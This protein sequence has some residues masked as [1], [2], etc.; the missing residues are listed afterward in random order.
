MPSR[1]IR[2]NL[3]TTEQRR[4]AAEID[5]E[6]RM[7][8]VVNHSSSATTGQ[9]RGQYRGDAVYDPL[10]RIY[11]STTVVGRSLARSASDKS[12]RSSGRQPGRPR[13][14]SIW[15]IVCRGS[16]TFSCLTCA[17]YFEMSICCRRRCF[18]E[19]EKRL[20]DSG[21]ETRNSRATCVS[22]PTFC[23][24]PHNQLKLTMDYKQRSFV[25]LKP[26]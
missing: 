11:L 26:S 2:L 22:R 8:S 23:T 12:D 14:A 4:L 3:F 9:L 1:D 15:R 10:A 19:D 25:V 17:C 18:E 7:N 5:D 24:V 13:V 6:L 16:T 20:A 21:I